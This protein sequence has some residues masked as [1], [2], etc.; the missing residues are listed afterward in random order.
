MATYAKIPVFLDGAY[1]SQVTRVGVVANFGII[2]VETLEE[3]AGFTNSAGNVEITIEFVIPSTGM[4][5]DFWNVGLNRT[6]VRAQ[7]GLGGSGSYA[8][9]GKFTEL[10]VGQAVGEVSNGSFTWR[11]PVRPME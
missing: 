9:T 5:Y 4:E 1:L 6:D 11:G 3:L 2:D 8:A 7:F 10:N